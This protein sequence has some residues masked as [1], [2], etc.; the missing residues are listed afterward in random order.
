[1]QIFVHK[2]FPDF[3]VHFAGRCL[4]VM[5]GCLLGMVPLL[6]INSEDESS[7]NKQD[8]DK[9]DQEDDQPVN[10]QDQPSDQQQ[11]K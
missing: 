11:N 10:K 8:G 6:F 2:M 9:Q 1:M 4:G 3:L 7:Q 5:L